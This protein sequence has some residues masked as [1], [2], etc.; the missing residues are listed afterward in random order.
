MDLWKVLLRDEKGPKGRTAVKVREKGLSMHGVWELDNVKDEAHQWMDEEV[1]KKWN[2][3]DWAVQVQGDDTYKS[4]SI[5]LPVKQSPT[6]SNAF[7]D[8][9]FT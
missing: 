6:G 3:E 4:V 2:H 1:M 8:G 7:K 9:V 5:P